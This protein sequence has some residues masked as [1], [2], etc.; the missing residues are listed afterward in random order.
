L[1]E[2][3]AALH[4]IH[5]SVLSNLQKKYLTQDKKFKK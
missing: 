5:Q 3:P 4:N 1:Q 2:E